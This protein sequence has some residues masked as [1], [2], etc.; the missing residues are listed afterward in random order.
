[1][2]KMS[3]LLLF[4]FCFLIF[5][6][7]FCFFT[8]F[9]LFFH[10]SEYLFPALGKNIYLVTYMPSCI[11]YFVLCILYMEIKKTQKTNNKTTPLKKKN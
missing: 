3:A 9:P 11:M 4:L 6:S 5:A 10:M 8:F 1:M 7:T 2:I